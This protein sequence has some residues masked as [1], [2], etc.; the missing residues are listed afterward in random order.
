MEYLFLVLWAIQIAVGFWIGWNKGRPFLGAVL[1]AVLGVLGWIIMAF[2]RPTYAEQ[3][4][5]EK[6]R[7]S[8]RQA[9]TPVLPGDRERLSQY[10][11]L[12]MTRDEQ[13]A[14][15]KDGTLPPRFRQEGLCG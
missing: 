11:I 3:V 14:Y 7:N 9:A 1:G 6:E 5:R 8:V 13:R 4:R 2:I 12:D 10:E 15:I